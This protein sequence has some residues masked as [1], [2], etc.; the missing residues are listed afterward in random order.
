VSDA[1]KRAPLND[2]IPELTTARLSIY[3]RCLDQLHAAGAGA[4]SSSALADRCGVNGALIRKDLAHFGELGVRG[5]GYHVDHLRRH[6]RQILGLDRR[7]AVVIL[8][9]GRL[10]SALA[11][12]GG[13]RDDGFDI[14]ALF[15]TD[16][17]KVGGATRD[18]IPVH[19]LDDLRAVVDRAS[20]AI[21]IVA[22]PAAVAQDVV[23]RVVDC[24]VRAILNFSP[25]A[26]RVPA[27]VKLK[28]MDATLALETLSFFLAS[29]RSHATDT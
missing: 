15:D 12:Y 28:N 16:A 19:T 22:V 13:F 11:E 8:G 21:A 18:G 4:V 20:V 14:V 23:D 26:P 24:G 7:T 27:G 5:V 1:W 10:G 2:Q 6:L 29:G 3:L 25:G 9:A 17:S